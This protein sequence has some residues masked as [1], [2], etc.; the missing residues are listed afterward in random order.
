[1]ACTSWMVS[2]WL[3]GCKL[4]WLS[5]R[6]RYAGQWR[7]LRHPLQ[8]RQ[9][10]HDAVHPDRQLAAKQAE[11]SASMGHSRP[12]A[13]RSGWVGH[14][15]RSAH[16]RYN[17]NFCNYS[18]GECRGDAVPSAG[19]WGIPSSLPSFSFAAAGGMNQVPEELRTFLKAISLILHSGKSVERDRVVHHN[20]MYKFTSIKMFLKELFI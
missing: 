7:G 16:C 2:C 18:A 11:R 6:S 3:S 9:V 13:G 19:V 14:R 8:S 12:N 20:L 17:K 4:T 15:Y 5:G 10:D 1:M